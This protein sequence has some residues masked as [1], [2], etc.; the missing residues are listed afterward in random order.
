MF[1]KIKLLLRTSKYT[2]WLYSKLYDL[3]YKNKIQNKQSHIQANGVETI[4]FLQNSLEKQG[5]NFFFDMGTLLG[6][7]R[8]G[9]LLKH[10]LDI[11]VAVFNEDEGEIAEIKNA[12]L[13][14]GC[15]HKFRYVVE[16]IGIVE[17]SYVL[18]NIKFDLSYYRKEDEKDICYLAYIDSEKNYPDNQLST[19]KLSCDKI[20]NTKKI[21]FEGFQINVPEKP[22]HYLS[23]RY[24]ENWTVP[25]KGY[26]YWKGPSTTPIENITIRTKM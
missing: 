4:K 25:D 23:Q 24:G 21:L 22:E 9:R 13:K 18:N 10:D 12:L 3:W 19:V 26:V 1:K 14:L 16:D 11:D 15:T 2:K 20:R 17:D 6:I 7:I 8:E 5:V